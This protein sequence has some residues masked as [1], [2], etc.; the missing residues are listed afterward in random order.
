M[1]EHA[2][3][4]EQ[5]VREILDNLVLSIGRQVTDAYQMKHGLWEGMSIENVRSKDKTEAA[6]N[7]KI[8]SVLEELKEQAEIIPDTLESRMFIT[9]NV[10]DATITDIQQGE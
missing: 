5:T 2:Q 9:T 7:A 3:L 6:I 10:I 8:V 1:T 4:S